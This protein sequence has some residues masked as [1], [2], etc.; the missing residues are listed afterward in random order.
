M[1]REMKV[2]CLYFP[3]SFLFSIPPSFI[4]K[5]LSLDDCWSMWNKKPIPSF[6]MSSGG[7]NRVDSLMYSTLDREWIERLKKRFRENKS[8]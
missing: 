7:R 4:A 8:I 6:S 1:K 5:Q 3:Y 2:W